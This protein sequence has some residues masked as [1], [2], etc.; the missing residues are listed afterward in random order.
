ML[1]SHLSNVDVAKLRIETDIAINIQQTDAF[2]GSLQEHLFAGNILLVGDWL[3]YD[4]L[5]ENHVFYK[6]S[7]L[8]DLSD[9]IKDCIVNYDKYKKMTCGNQDKMHNISS[10]RVAAKRI[11]V[12]YDDMLQ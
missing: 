3:P 4:I 2:S 12:I 10:W 11:S 8:T 1:K 6:K 7:S 5:D 9:Q